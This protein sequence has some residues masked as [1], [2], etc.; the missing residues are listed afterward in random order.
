MKTTRV[1]VVDDDAGDRQLLAR[2]LRGSAE[3]VEIETASD[4][5]EFLNSLDH[6]P[7]DCIV[8]DYDLSECSADELLATLRNSRVA[9]PTIVVS[10][11][12]TQDVAVR[13]LRCGGVDF[14]NKDDAF[15]ADL[16]WKRIQVA[17]TRR[18]RKTAERRKTHRRMK[19]LAHLAEED[20][21]TGLLN[22][23]ALEHK[24]AQDQRSCLDRRGYTSVVM[25]DIDHFKRVNDAYGHLFG[26][27]VLK[28][29]AN[30]VRCEVAKS[31]LTVR[32]G[33]EEFLV[34]KPGAPLPRA[35][36]WAD[37]LCRHIADLALPVGSECVPITVS[38]GIASDRS[39]AITQKT[40][41]RADE[42]LYRAK[43]NGRNRV[44]IWRPGARRPNGYRPQD[45]P[46]PSWETRAGSAELIH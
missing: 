14:L 42:A 4:V 46:Q 32:W 30:K 28:A 21:L 45:T 34:V 16:L 9:C 2:T 17:L 22:R 19:R 40:I 15:E 25:L 5:N 37:Q 11:S 20:P 29:V 44:C 8:M 6:K 18:R 31:D 10:G 39:A 3:H 33:G 12:R 35:V 38:A 1:L 24:I 23:R 13:S 7:F 41:E 27:R 36:A 43:Q 26:D